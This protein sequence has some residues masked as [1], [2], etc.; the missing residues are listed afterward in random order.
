MISGAVSVP[1]NLSVSDDALAGMLMDAGVTALIATD[2]QAHRIAA[3]AGSSEV[4]SPSKPVPK[5]CAA[6]TTQ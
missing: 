2:D 6:W 3:M 1:I 5:P 4:S